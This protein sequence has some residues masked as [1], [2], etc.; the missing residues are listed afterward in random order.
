[1]WNT[2]LYRTVVE[3]E[4]SEVSVG[5][6]GA[7]NPKLWNPFECELALQVSEDLVVTEQFDAPDSEADRLVWRTHDKFRFD[8]GR[9]R[10]DE[11]VVVLTHFSAFY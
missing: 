10:G 6:A 7:N 1:M 5:I 2:Q 11:V 4:I 3:E 8:A 9:E